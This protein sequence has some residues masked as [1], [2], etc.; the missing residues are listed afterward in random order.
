MF[1]IQRSVHV[2]NHLYKWRLLITFENSSGPTKCS[3][4]NGC[5]CSLVS[6]F[7]AREESVRCHCRDFLVID[8]SSLI[9]KI[10]AFL[11]KMVKSWCVKLNLKVN[12]SIFCWRCII[13]QITCPNVVWLFSQINSFRHLWLKAC[14]RFPVVS[15]V[16][17]VREKSVK[18]WKKFKV[19]EKSGNFDLSQGN[20]KF[21][22]KSGNF[23]TTRLLIITVQ[24][25]RSMYLNSRDVK[26]FRQNMI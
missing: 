14:L 16:T 5:M 10:V 23:M 24:I 11:K 18:K 21:W 22:K 1:F 8:K 9:I 17:T 12:K 3:C 15:R 13:T 4:E 6:A 19:R 26:T 7:A 25:S 20:L 2:N